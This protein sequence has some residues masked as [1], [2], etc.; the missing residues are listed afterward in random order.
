MKRGK[1]FATYGKKI[2]K[3]LRGLMLVTAGCLLLGNVSGCG[4]N[5]RE[6][7]L[8]ESNRTEKEQAD[9]LM[10]SVLEALEA[11]DA[12]ALKELFSAYAL[13]NAYDLDGKIEELM[14]FYP[15]CNGGYEGNVRSHRTSDRGET[16]YVIM[17]KYTVTND[18]KTYE[19]RFTTYIENDVEA[20]RLGL[21]IIEV[22][23]EEAKPDGFKWKDEED[24]PGIYVLE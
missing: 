17:P 4:L 2:I 8:A 18:D 22:M 3:G 13:E 21:H 20:E 16:V 23:T 5:G 6:E 9:E 19:M 24:E 10:Q 1:L 11:R 7:H 12:E 14:D 15:G